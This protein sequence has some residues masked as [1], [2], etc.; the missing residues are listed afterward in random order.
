[1]LRN[2]GTSQKVRGT[3]TLKMRPRS[4]DLAE[5][6]PGKKMAEFCHGSSHTR[7][8]ESR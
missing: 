1:M 3:V 8:V 2:E 4:G 6:P 5:T 7:T